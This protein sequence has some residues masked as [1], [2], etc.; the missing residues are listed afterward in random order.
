MSI[1][2]VICLIKLICPICICICN[3]DRKHTRIRYL[4]VLYYV[5]EIAIIY[6]IIN[7]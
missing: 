6:C 4:H 7:M 5:A 2:N 1:H 3:S